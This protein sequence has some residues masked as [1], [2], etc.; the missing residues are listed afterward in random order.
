MLLGGCPQLNTQYC[1]QRPGVGDKGRVLMAVALPQ[2]TNMTELSRSQV[3]CTTLYHADEHRVVRIHTSALGAKGD[4][5]DGVTAALCHDQH[6]PYWFCAQVTF[7]PRQVTY[8]QL[9][10]VFFQRHDP[11][12]LNRQVTP[13]SLHR[14]SSCD[15]SSHH[16]P[17]VARRRATLSPDIA[18]ATMIMSV[19]STVA[20]VQACARAH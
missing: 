14:N 4:Q 15:A 13:V 20:R 10:E 1:C 5:I 18:P 16:E 3:K 12:Q 9:L 11:T 2:L 17:P 8:E 7:D 19:R 6:T